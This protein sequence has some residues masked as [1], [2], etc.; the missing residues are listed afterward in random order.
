MPS[1][2]RS[3]FSLPGQFLVCSLENDLSS[4]KLMSGCYA[5]DW[6]SANTTVLQHSKKFANWQEITSCV[7]GMRVIRGSGFY[8]SRTL[9]STAVKY[10]E[11]FDKISVYRQQKK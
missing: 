11:A 3:F 1:R 9:E 8:S 10:R 6:L 7:N 4:S 5:M 2:I